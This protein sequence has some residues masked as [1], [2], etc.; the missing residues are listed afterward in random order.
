M[1][2]S[3][4]VS[5]GRR[6]LRRFRQSTA[7][8]A[9]L[10]AVQPGSAA[11]A[12]MSAGLLWKK[13]TGS[14]LRACQMFIA[15]VV[16]ELGWPEV[17]WKT[18]PMGVVPH[19]CPTQQNHKWYWETYIKVFVEYWGSDPEGTWSSAKEAVIEAMEDAFPHCANQ[20]V[21]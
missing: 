17:A 5:H 18:L 14:G 19:H 10:L 15:E 13:C 4:S 1:T 11:A 2:M 8:L 12:D 6:A 7:V 9:L 16:E 20:R 3:R 21:S